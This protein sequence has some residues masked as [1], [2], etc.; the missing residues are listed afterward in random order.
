MINAPLLQTIIYNLTVQFITWRT[1]VKL[2]RY[3]FQT[4]NFYCKTLRVYLN[5]T[6]KRASIDTIIKF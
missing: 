4:N 2:Y 1:D 5:K 3:K 6:Q